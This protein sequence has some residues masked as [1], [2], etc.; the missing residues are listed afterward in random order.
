LIDD[1]DKTERTDWSIRFDLN[2]H[3]NPEDQFGLEFSGNLNQSK[4][5]ADLPGK[6]ASWLKK[7]VQQLSGTDEGWG[8]RCDFCGQYETDDSKISTH[9]INQVPICNQCFNSEP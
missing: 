4:S 3:R 5:I 1:D 7:I 6:G 8:I 9:G 2:E